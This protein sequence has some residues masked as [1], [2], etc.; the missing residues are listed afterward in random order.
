MDQQIA[1]QKAQIER[2]Y[3]EDVVAFTSSVEALGSSLKSCA[4]SAS[5]R[6]I[7]ASSGETQYLP[8]LDDQ[9]A[10]CGD[11]EAHRQALLRRGERLLRNV[12]EIGLGNPAQGYVETALKDLK[13]MAK[14]GRKTRRGK[15]G[16]KRTRK[17]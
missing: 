8:M 5:L 15:V 7:Y 17:H 13:A 9:I 10:A 1:A 12:M 11:L 16:G 3:K 4:A 6:K 2:V 14:G